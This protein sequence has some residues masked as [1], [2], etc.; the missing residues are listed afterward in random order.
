VD[1]NGPTEFGHTRENGTEL[2]R[3]ERLVVDIG[4]Q[5]KAP[6]VQ[7]RDTA[8]EFPERCLR[9]PEAQSRIAP[10]AVRV[11]GNEFGQ[12]IVRNPGQL[13]GLSTPYP[14][15]AG[16]GKTQ[17][18]DVDTGLIHMRQLGLHVVQG[19]QHGNGETLTAVE[20]IRAVHQPGVGEVTPFFERTGDVF[21]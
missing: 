3:V 6:K 9:V 10:E 18:G 17:D 19:R 21:G 1:K 16:H 12:Q 4:I 7:F 11:G 13:V 15:R 5:L 8:V 2:G 14:V 20:M